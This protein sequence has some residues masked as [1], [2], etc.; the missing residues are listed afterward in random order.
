MVII[1]KF[2]ARDSTAFLQLWGRGY[3]VIQRRPADSPVATALRSTAW[4]SPESA[5][6]NLNGIQDD[7]RFQ[8]LTEYLKHAFK[9]YAALTN[10]L[11]S[12]PVIADNK[13]LALHTS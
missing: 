4:V 9:S 3:I 8:V 13:S 6:P 2:R 1:W 7:A 11:G 10:E 12:Q 5:C